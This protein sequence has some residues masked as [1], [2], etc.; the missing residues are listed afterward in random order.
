MTY[1]IIE[2]TN[3]I[4]YV[5]SIAKNEAAYIDIDDHI[6]TRNEMSSI[7][8]KSIGSIFAIAQRDNFNNGT[9]SL[10]FRSDSDTIENGWAG[11]SD[12]KIRRHFGWRGT[13]DNVGIYGMGPAKLI[14]YK[15]H[16]KTYRTVLVFEKIQVQD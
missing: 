15:Q 7:N 14:S 9:I 10:I 11:N 6:T 2:T 8:E 13:T 12:P 4:K 3:Q 1:K 5:V 16:P